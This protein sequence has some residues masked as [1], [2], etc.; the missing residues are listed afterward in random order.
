MFR[1]CC[2]LGQVYYDN[3]TEAGYSLQ[4]VNLSGTNH[5]PSLLNLNPQKLFLTADENQF[6]YAYKDFDFVTGFPS[7]CDR[8]DLEQFKP[9]ETIDQRFYLTE[10]GQ[11]IFHQ[12]FKFLDFKDY[13]IEELTKHEDFSKVS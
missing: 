10:S 4:C 13:C 2:G 8:Y 9:D 3:S 6:E 12:H 11:L 5:S 7:N 1:K